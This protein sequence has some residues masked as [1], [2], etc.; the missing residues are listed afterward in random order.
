MKMKNYTSHSI[1]FYRYEDVIYNENIRKNLVK[2]GARP[3]KTLPS[4]GL[5]NAEINMIPSQ[6]ILGIPCMSRSIQIP[7][8]EL[9]KRCLYIVSV[10]F[11]SAI[12]QQKPELRDKFLTVGETVWESTDGRLSICG[13][14]NLVK[15]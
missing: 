4:E 7:N 8:I 12:E 10:Q 14:L 15:Y 11:F 9:E 13:C 2:E 6:E 3:Y 1:N 5:L